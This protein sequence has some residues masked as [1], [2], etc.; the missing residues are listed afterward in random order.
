[1]LNIELE[2][3]AERDN[4]EMRITNMAE[5]QR[6]V[7]AEWTIL[8]DKLEKLQVAG[9]KVVLSKLPIGDVATMWF[10]DRDMFCAGRVPEDDLQRIMASCGGQIM[11]TV[12]QIG[13]ES[14]GKCD[15]FYEQQVSV[16]RRLRRWNGSKIGWDANWG[17]SERFKIFEN[18]GEFQKIP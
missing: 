6:V 13:D 11:T 14:L 4:A 18:F 3:R 8:Y 16:G 7:D 10:A 5:Y 1:V 15:E 12:S 2:L 9:A 17:F